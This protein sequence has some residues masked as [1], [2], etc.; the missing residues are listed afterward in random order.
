MLDV[1]HP[2]VLSVLTNVT[3][4]P[5]TTTLFVS[6]SYIKAYQQIVMADSVRVPFVNAVALL[7]LHGREIWLLTNMAKDPT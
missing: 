3:V 6:N 2:I 4:T 5:P 7:V 1:L